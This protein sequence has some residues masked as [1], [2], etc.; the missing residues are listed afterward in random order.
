MIINNTFSANVRAN[1]VSTRLEIDYYERQFDVLK[2][3]IDEDELFLY[4]R[5]SDAIEAG[6]KCMPQGNSLAQKLAIAK[7]KV[8]MAKDILDKLR[9]F[10]EKRECV[11]REKF[12]IPFLWSYQQET[13]VV[14]DYYEQPFEMEGI[15]IPFLSRCLEWKRVGWS[16]SAKELRVS[17]TEFCSRND[18]GR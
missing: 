9:Q 5:F 15:A 2:N 8:E 18:I 4:S 14:S 3:K 7:R 11:S 16:Y 17:A 1:D 6:E 10:P 13:N 12:W